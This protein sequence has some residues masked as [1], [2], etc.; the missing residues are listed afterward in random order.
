MLLFIIINIYI[1]YL[2][3]FSTIL[4]NVEMEIVLPGNMTVIE[5]HDLAL[6]LQHKI[7]SLEDIERTFVHVR[8]F[9]HT[10]AFRSC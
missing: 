7:E 2:S 1:Y 8:S 5:S 9:H 3:Y 10:P 4:V 6:A